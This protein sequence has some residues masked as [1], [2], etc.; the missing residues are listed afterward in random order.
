MKK[1]ATDCYKL[2]LDSM[3]ISPVFA[4]YAILFFY[5]PIF[6]HNIEAAKTQ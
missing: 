3:A 5:N 1:S 4:Q 2:N 6:A